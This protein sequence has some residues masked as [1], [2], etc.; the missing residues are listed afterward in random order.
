MWV[1]ILDF[2]LSWFAHPSITGIALAIAFGIVWLSPFWPPLIHKP[3]LWAVLVASALLSLVA[4][5]LVQIP[6]QV[7]VGQ[8][9]GSFWSQ[10]VLVRW[11]LLAGIP[12]VLLSGLVQEGAKLLPVVAWWWRSGRN[13]TPRMGLLI[14]AVA[15]AGLGIFEA[16]W[17]H[18]IILDAGWTWA[19][20]SDGGLMTLAGFWERFVVVA[21]HIS[22]SA[23]AGYGLA[24][25]WGWQ[26]YL[27]AAFLHSMVNYSA[28]Y[29]QSGLFTL[30]Q[31]EV[32]VTVWVVLVTGGA[33]W[34]RWR[35]TA[36]LPAAENEAATVQAGESEVGLPTD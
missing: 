15:G 30:V 1:Q 18:G 32:Y 31:V 28:V 27:L 20:V 2:F 21:F 24:R 12:Q 25:G 13:I 33:L 16:Q 35:D 3:R 8:A 11:I 29:M 6:L 19:M 4:V 7:L 26:F 23:L 14:G 36:V 9:L 22:V 17:V 5:S 10:E 34:L